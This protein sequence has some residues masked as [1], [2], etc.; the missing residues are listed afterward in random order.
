MK[1]IKKQ[2]KFVISFVFYILF[3]S[4]LGCKENLLT[5]NPFSKPNTFA[6]AD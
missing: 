2:V 5:Y 3:L 1:S 4:F 6:K